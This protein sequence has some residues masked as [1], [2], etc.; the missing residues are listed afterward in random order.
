MSVQTFDVRLNIIND[1]Y[2]EITNDIVGGLQV[3][4]GIAGSGLLDR[5]ASTGTLKFRLR[6]VNNI[7]TPNHINCLAKFA[8]GTAVVALVRIRPSS[9]YGFKGTISQIDPIYGD[10]IT[11][12]V[13][14]TVVDYIDMLARHELQLPAFAQNKKMEEVVALIIANMPVAPDLT[15]YGAGQDTFA[16]VFDT[17]RSTTRALTEL[18]KVTQSELGMTWVE[19]SSGERLCTRG[20]NGFQSIASSATFTDADIIGAE[21]EYGADYYNEVVTETYPRRVDA[22]AT[23][24]LFNLDR[25]VSVGAGETVTISGSYSDPDQKAVEVS[26]IDMV[27]PAATTDYLFNTAED[28]TG[29]NIT[30]NLTVTATY[31]ANGVNYELTNSYGSTGYVTKLQARG[32]GVYTFQPVTYSAE[33]STGINAHGRRTLRV[34]MPYQDNPL[35]GVDFAQSV[36][37]AV[38]AIGLRVTSIT[39]EANKSAALAAAFV[40]LNIG[41]RITIELSDFGLSLD[42]FI[43]RVDVTVSEGGLVTCTY[44]LLDEALTLAGSYWILD[45]ASYSQ[46]DETTKLGF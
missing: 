19:T 46:L 4:Q 22:S 5:T 36:L 37:D 28:G 29:T 9:Y 44:G 34:D 30:A 7:Y 23:S 10:G 18:A 6:N 31:G 33:Y 39:Y 42:A 35:V 26:G 21:I 40:G 43:T 38:K 25:P 1:D 41:D 12:Y 8:V 11:N 15:D 16:T 45:S 2:D 24:V 13:N 20:R 27:T 3:T 14:V 32:K 17:T